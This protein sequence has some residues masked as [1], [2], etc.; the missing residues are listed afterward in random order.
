MRAWRSKLSLVAFRI[1][2]LRAISAADRCEARVTLDICALSKQRCAACCDVAHVTLFHVS[3][4]AELALVVAKVESLGASSGA[5][6]ALQR[7]L[8][9]QYGCIANQAFAPG[10]SSVHLALVADLM[11]SSRSHLAQI[12]ALQVAARRKLWRAQRCGYVANERLDE[13][14]LACGVDCRGSRRR[15]A[16]STCT[17]VRHRPTLSLVVQCKRA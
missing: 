12:V 11:W 8:A 15:T 6:R 7:N 2:R 9:A 5:G 3:R 14:V 4:G 10:S 1:V 17:P 16:V 13:P